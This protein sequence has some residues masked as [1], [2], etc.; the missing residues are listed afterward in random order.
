MPR[1]TC[2]HKFPRRA[3]S[4]PPPP[5]AAAAVRSRHP[6]GTRP[7]GAGRAG[8]YAVHVIDALD[9]TDY[10]KESQ[11]CCSMAADEPLPDKQGKNTG[12]AQ[13]WSRRTARPGRDYD[14]NSRKPAFFGSPQKARA[15]PSPASLFSSIHLPS[16]STPFSFPTTEK[17]PRPLPICL[18]LLAATAA[19]MPA[20]SPPPSSPLT[21]CRSTACT[22]AP[23]AKSA[24]RPAFG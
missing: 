6:G 16:S 21:Q 8:A 5:S 14:R 7:S 1:C 24:S 23:L 20:A 9:A 3:G 4:A 2:V 22:Y 19:A 18:F 15:D 11:H 17:R 13:L 10:S 12:P